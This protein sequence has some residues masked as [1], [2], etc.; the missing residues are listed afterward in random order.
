MQL[1]LIEIPNQARKPTATPTPPPSK[2]TKQA[3]ARNEWKT[4]QPILKS[5]IEVLGAIDLDPCSNSNT[6]MSVPAKR[7]YGPDENSLALPWNGR[8]WL[9]PPFGRVIGTWMTKL[10][11]EYEKGA[12]TAAIA[13]IPTRTDAAWWGHLAG[14]PFCAVRGKITFVRWDRK[15]SPSYTV[16]V[17]YLGPQLSRF[18]SVFS[19]FGTIYIPYNS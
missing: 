7:Y 4:P 19:P 17:V 6:I 8:V 13:L 10:C 14:Y 18:A 15:R 16:S 2:E 11:D 5:V 3:V 1:P 12:C 9:N